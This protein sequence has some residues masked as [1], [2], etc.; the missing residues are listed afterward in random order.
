MTGV[1]I[2]VTAADTDELS[3]QV[4]RG[5]DRARRPRGYPAGHGG[6]RPGPGHGGRRGRP[7]PAGRRGDGPGGRAG[8]G[9]RPAQPVP[10][11][12]AAS[13]PGASRP[14]AGRLAMGTLPGQRPRYEPRNLAFADG[15]DRWDLDRGF[16][17]EADRRPPDYSAAADGPSAVLSS[18]VPRPA[19]PPPWSRRSSPTITAAPRSCSAARS[20]PSP[21][22]N[23]PG[24]AWRSSGTGGA[25]GAPARTTVSRSL[26]AA[27]GPGMRSRR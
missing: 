25:T 20:A 7:G 16:R 3:P 6:P 21:S 9:R 1:D 27:T 2:D 13:R 14:C 17:R 8:T 15:L 4:S 18:A 5:A 10:R 22:P 11:P 24:F 19:D 12:R 23:R 26:A